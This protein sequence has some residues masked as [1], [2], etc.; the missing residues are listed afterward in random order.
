MDLQSE[1]MPGAVEK[2][3]AS[4]IAHFRRKSAP[5]KQLGDR[6]VDAHPIH[7]GFDLIQRQRL[8]RFH[9]FPKLALF[10]ARAPANHRSRHVTPVTRLRLT[11]ENV[12]NDQ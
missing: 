8:A 5:V 1:S 3:D 11:R 2:P 6:L 4:A 9:R 12:E 10:L 7:A